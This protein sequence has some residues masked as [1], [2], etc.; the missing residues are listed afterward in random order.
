MCRLL[1]KF[2]KKMRLSQSED[3]GKKFPVLVITL[4]YRVQAQRKDDW[5]IFKSNV[6]LRRL[7][8][9]SLTLIGCT[10]LSLVVGMSGCASIPGKTGAEQAE[11]IDALVERTL[12]DLYKQDPKS[13]EEIANSVGY[14]IGS[15]KITKIPIV[16]AG[17]GY[18]VAINNKTGEKTYLKIVRFDI[19]GGWGARSVRPVMI[20]QDEKK[21]KDFID[22]VWSASAGAEAAAKVQGAGAA[23]GAG[24]GNL[25]GDKGYSIH[26][27][28]DAGVS[29]T[30]TVGVIRVKPVK[31]KK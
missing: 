7:I 5:N 21:F 18:G 22:G 16:G 30:V 26:F 13:K 20:F 17:S 14:A 10:L 19:G 11:A 31:L 8:M 9:R 28:T 25:P 1:F 29:A 23:G 2:V 6:F 12:T 3:Y 15:N 27:I 24:S 4:D